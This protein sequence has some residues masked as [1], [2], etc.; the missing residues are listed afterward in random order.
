MSHLGIVDHKHTGR[1]IH[2]RHSSYPLLIALLIAI[3]G[4]LY[5]AQQSVGAISQSV[6]VTA[7]VPGPPPKIGARFALQQNHVMATQ[8]V[9][10]LS[11][12][13]ASQTVVV[14]A[15]N[16]Q[17][18]GSTPCT[19]N[20]A[21]SLPV[22]LQNGTNVLQAYDYDTLNQTGPETPILVVTYDT[23]TSSV[24]AAQV[25]NST[26]LK[27]S[28]PLLNTPTFMSACYNFKGATLTST[29]TTSLGVITGCILRGIQP[30]EQSHLG[31]TTYGGTLPYTASID[32]GDK[33]TS[34]LKI[35]DSSYQLI[36]FT[37]RSPGIYTVA[38]HLTDARGA[39]TFMQTM[40][41]VDGA[42]TAI[43]STTTND[44]SS[45]LAWLEEIPIPV[46]IFTL[47]LTV[48]LWIVTLAERHF[49]PHLYAK[50]R[51]A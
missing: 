15:N 20:G 45:A 33:I 51:R 12:S 49:K 3:G 13:C 7:T 19:T 24:S 40:I 9:L 46:Y 29:T 5:S 25:Q 14:V 23:A 38:I 11:G 37:Y 44:A 41:E 1:L 26:A 34:I 30:G 48:C 32:W 2:H 18:A 16:G 10:P 35:T 21:F 36:P 27:S 31:L 6:T 42:P 4:F 28:Y 17:T 47:S 22:Q 43:V 50:K 8:N 39:T